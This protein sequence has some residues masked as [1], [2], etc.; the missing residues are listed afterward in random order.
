MISDNTKKPDKFVFQS[1]TVEAGGTLLV[2]ASATDTDTIG[3][4]TTGG[5]IHL[6]LASAVRARS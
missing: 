1:G 3:G 4:T 5:R 6:R 2:Y